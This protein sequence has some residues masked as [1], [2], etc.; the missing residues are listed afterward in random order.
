MQALE[1]RLA[2]VE[3]AL[4]FGGKNTDMV[5]LAAQHTRLRG[6]VDEAILAWETAA[7][8]QEALG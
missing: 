8:E 2:E 1:A 3:T 5:G 4:S 7:A 6:D